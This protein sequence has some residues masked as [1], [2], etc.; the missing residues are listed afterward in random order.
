M[1][2]LL[3]TLDNFIKDFVDITP[4]ENGDFGHFPFQCFTVTKDNKLE[5]GALA[6]G[7]D[8][9]AC[10]KYF[11]LAVLKDARQVFMSVDFPANEFI[12]TD[13]VAVFYCHRQA[14]DVVA[15]PYNTATGEKFPT[16]TKSPVLDEIKQNLKDVLNGKIK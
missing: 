8:V 6:L 1:D 2:K 15:I 7:G 4:Q 12:K 9:V 5:I 14:I 3:T 11:S 16:L 10:L 13:F